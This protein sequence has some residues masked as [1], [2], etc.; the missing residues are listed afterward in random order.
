MQIGLL[1]LVWPARRQVFERHI[2]YMSRRLLVEATVGDFAKLTASSSGDILVG[3]KIAGT[4]EFVEA[5]RGDSRGL[6]GL[7]IGS[8]RWK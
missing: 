3:Q 2:C 6:L 7:H 8:F 1:P 4:E 5:S